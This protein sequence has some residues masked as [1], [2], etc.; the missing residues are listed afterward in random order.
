MFLMNRAANQSLAERIVNRMMLHDRICH[1]YLPVLAMLLAL[2]ALPART[3]AEIDLSTWAADHQLTRALKDSM[4]REG[5][6]SPLLP[7]DRVDFPGLSYFP[8]DERF[9]VVGQFHRYS[10]VREI[11]IPDT[12]GT[13]MFVERLGRFHFQWDGK[14]FWLEV[15]GSTRDDDMSVYFTDRTNGISTY[16]AGR[17]APVRRTEDGSYLIDF[18]NAY[19]PYC[20]YN[21]AY[22][23]PLPPPENRLSFAVEAGEVI[24]G[25]DLAH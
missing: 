17:Y 20:A 3:D 4:F 2:G 10:R 1:R 25:P 6:N 11:E 18:N 16:P 8:L 23:C 14:A 22:I 24:S 12:K 13:R 7:E 21:P 15:M 19:S 5:E 9:H